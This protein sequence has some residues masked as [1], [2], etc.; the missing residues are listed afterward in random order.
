[1]LETMDMEILREERM[2]RLRE[3][4]VRLRESFDLPEGA[5]V[6]PETVAGWQKAAG[7]LLALLTTNGE[8]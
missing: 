4:L 8:S 6:S 2:M 1:M 5:T 3:G 7:D